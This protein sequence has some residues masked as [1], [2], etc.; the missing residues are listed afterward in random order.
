MEP[1]VRYRSLMHDSARWDRFRLRAGDVVVSTPPKAGTTWTQTICLMLV[2][3]TTELGAPVSVLSPWLDQQVLAI[4]DV[5][6]ALDAQPGRRV[7][8]THTPLDGLPVVEAV[9]YVCVARD[10]HDMA[11]SMVDHQS[12]IDMERVLAL[13]EQAVGN[14]DLA[15]FGPAP[16]TLPDPAVRLREW[17]LDNPPYSLSSLQRCLH[18]WTTF[19]DV[20]DDPR[21][22]LFHYIDLREDRVAEVGWLAA[23]LGLAPDR[24]RDV[25]IADAVAFDRMRARPADFAPN[26][27]VHMWKDDEA[28]FRAGRRDSAD[29]AFDADLRAAY[30][31]I[32]AA[33]STPEMAAW[34]H[35]GRRARG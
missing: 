2:H 23:L 21:I 33:Q 20:A 4:D 3:D 10:P 19:W 16:G 32:V 29:V 25:A 34:V 18:H 6:A 14:D 22:G 35:H 15:D 27:V 8:K 7:I 9:T 13:R 5:V 12:N 11:L 30:D 1:R 24:D 31:E 28:F 17:V 26:A